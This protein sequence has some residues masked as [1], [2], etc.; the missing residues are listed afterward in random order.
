MLKEEAKGLTED[1][2]ILKC[3]MDFFKLSDSA[4][5]VNRSNAIEDI[6]FAAGDQWT[7][8]IQ[9]SRQLEA[10]PT[11]TLNK[12]EPF[13]RQVTNAQRQQRP[14][15]KVH[16]I[17]DQADKQIS[18]ILAG[19]CRHI[20]VN[21]NADDA[22]DT[23]YD[24]AVRMGWGYWRIMHDYI[25]EKSFQ[26]EIFIKPIMN[27]FTVNFDP[28]SKMLDGSDAENV[29]IS[30]MVKKK[31][32]EEM[33]P[34]VEMV[35]WEN[36]QGDTQPDWINQEEIRIAEFFY[37]ER[38]P[39]DLHMLEDGSTMWADDHKKRGSEL[40]VVGT[41]KS[42]RKIIK[43]CKLTHDKVLEKKIWAGK[44]I[45]V[46]PVYGQQTY[47]D[48]KM[49][50]FGIVRNAKDA[51]RMYNYWMSATTEY[52]ALAPKA[53]W[54]IAEG[55]DEG[56]ELDWQ[57]ANLKNQSVLRFKTTNLDGDPIPH[58]PQRIPPA[59][60]PEGLLMAAQ[61][62]SADIQS[63][64]GVFDAAQQETGNQSGKALLGQQM[65]MD[66]NNF[67]YFD[68]LSKSIRHTGKV[69]LDLIPK[70]YDTERVMRIIGADGRPDLVEINKLDEN[71]GKILNDVSVG[72]YD[73]E[74]DVGPAYATRRL[75][76]VNSLAPLLEGNPELFQKIGDL[77]FRNLDFPASEVIADRLAADNPLSQIDQ[78]SEI[79]PQVQMHIQKLQ[80]DNQQLQEQ[81]QGAEIAIKMRTDVEQFKQAGATER[82]I[83]KAEGKA[84]DRQSRH[85][86]DLNRTFMQA[87]S[88]QNVAEINALTALALKGV[89]STHLEAELQR[90]DRELDQA[91][92]QAKRELQADENPR[93]Q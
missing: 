90:R 20:E 52:I 81:L 80:Q 9:Q 92:N 40:Q 54:L 29:L 10:R 32:F 23:A 42:E 38:E 60:P 19:L 49:E 36:I 5:G 44:Y 93:V 57:N 12:L 83:I 26:Q 22:Y 51:Q 27:P 74:M 71:T 17:N 7:A 1:E 68:N 63:I 3:A 31:D 35:N 28:F 86:T 4:E 72:L 77:F 33:Y 45:P 15:I 67:H 61:I 11:L 6:K 48:G 50:R 64:V 91:E 73:V 34:D 56:H 62:V 55:Q 14:R 2:K 85:E 69:L 82:E 41:R 59:P 79:P 25:D 75:E 30:E 53:P 24:F 84:Y 37:T 76:F 89:D 78:N 65:Q 39:Q 43:W 88:A 87:E 13:I 70:I 8:T 66:L 58:I 46:I 47:I 16:P 18:D 21:S